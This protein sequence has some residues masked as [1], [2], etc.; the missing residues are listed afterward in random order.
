MYSIALYSFCDRNQ[1]ILFGKVLN[2]S[3][4]ES[5][6]ICRWPG[7]CKYFLGTIKRIVLMSAMSSKGSHPFQKLLIVN[8][9]FTH[10]AG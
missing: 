9:Q 8:I 7:D 1:C 6:D 10:Y 5:Q 4:K 3:L 2:I